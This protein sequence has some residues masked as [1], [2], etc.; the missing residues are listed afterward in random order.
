MKTLK[1]IYLCVVFVVFLSGCARVAVKLPDGTEINYSRLGNQEIGLFK[2]NR[3]GTASFE[4]QK[5]NH[6]TLYG[7]I[8][9]LV[10][11]VP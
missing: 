7:A 2:L 10:D 4:G 8:D 11:K 6:E 1:S 3:D 9:K 5:S